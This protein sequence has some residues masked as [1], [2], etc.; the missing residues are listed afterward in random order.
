MNNESMWD[1]ID[2]LLNLVEGHG[3]LISK[4][5]DTNL[6]MAK[7]IRQLETNQNG[8]QNGTAN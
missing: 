3:N 1:L 2:K 4:L 8:V 5:T 7:R 6:E